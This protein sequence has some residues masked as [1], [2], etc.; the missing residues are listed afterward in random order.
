M[1]ADIDR[2]KDGLITLEEFIDD[3]C[4]QNRRYNYLFN[5]IMTNIHVQGI[6]QNNLDFHY[7][8]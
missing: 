5:L 7:K 8:I 2:N 6:I 1:F 3:V 4:A